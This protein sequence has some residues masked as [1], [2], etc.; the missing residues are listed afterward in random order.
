M[1]MRPKSYVLNCAHCGSE[2][3]P[4]RKNQIHCSVRCRRISYE[5]RRGRAPEDAD[6][7]RKLVEEARQKMGGVNGGNHKSNG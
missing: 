4:F 2:F 6:S 7:H 3:H 5:E 1:P